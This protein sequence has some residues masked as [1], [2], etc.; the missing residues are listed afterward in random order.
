M[1]GQTKA[2]R[3]S[4]AEEYGQ[5]KFT[6]NF[7]FCKVMENNL[8]LCRKMLEIILKVK[9]QKVVIADKEKTIDITPDGKSVRLDVYVEDESGTIYNIEMQVSSKRDL[10]RRSRYYQGMIDLNLIEKGAKYSGLKKSFVIFICLFDPFQKN[11]PVYIFTNKCTEM[12]ELELGDGT[13]KVFINP[14]GKTEGLSEDMKA[15]LKYLREGITDG[16]A[17]TD[18]LEQEVEKARNH[19]EWR[20]E[21]MS[22]RLEFEDAIDDAMAEGEARGEVRGEERK[23][24]ELVV[25]KLRK[26]KTIDQIADELEEDVTKVSRIVEAAQKYAPEYDIKQI[27][28][29]L[30]SQMAVI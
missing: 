2:I 29:E 13:A 20:K 4:L 7:L 14:F 21:Y 9:I 6:N 17:F 16:N 28:K 22:W 24:I 12:P 15:F 11:L 3:S 19:V 26:H 30:A 27:Q 10:P 18:E 23:L 8:E 25:R 5:L 1:D